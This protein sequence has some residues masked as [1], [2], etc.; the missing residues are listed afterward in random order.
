MCSSDIFLAVLAVFFPP[1]AV[2][3]KS[4]FCTADSI[5]NITLTLLCFF[6]GLIHAWYIILKYPEPNDDGV[7]YEP[8]PGGGSRRRDL[9]NGNVTYYYVSHQQ[10]HPSNRGYGT[11]DTHNHQSPGPATKSHNHPEP[12]GHAGSSSAPPPPTYAEAVKG[13]NKVQNHD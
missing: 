12:S 11:V 1:I 5:I 6:P 8:I 10:Q 2:W 3:V 7:A 9:E 4:G 13:D